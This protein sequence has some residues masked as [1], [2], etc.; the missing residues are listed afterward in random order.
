M[1]IPD[2][3]LDAKTLITTAALSAYVLKKDVDKAKE[4][5]NEKDAPI[6][7]VLSAFVFAAQM[8]NFPVMAGTSGHFL[9]AALLTYMMGPHLAGLAMS[10][11]LILQCLLFQ[12][13]G[14]LALGA[15]ILN[16]AVAAPL[17]A[18]YVLKIIDSKIPGKKT[19]GLV[20]AGWSSVVIAAIFCS[21]EL[22]A[23]GVGKLQAIII[24]MLTIHALIG[25]GEG[26][27]TVAVVSFIN[28]VRKV[29]IE[30]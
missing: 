1:H 16:M 14:L 29:K 26:L 13:G 5:L 28:K 18:Y 21:F 2:G 25:I 20:L 4:I 11:V 17:T 7:G 9:G 27:I 24:P 15:N 30:F 22:Y 12:D 3:F 19:F 6:L 23:S 8:V 10:A